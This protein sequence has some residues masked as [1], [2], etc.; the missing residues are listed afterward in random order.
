MT[1]D[2]NKVEPFGLGQYARRASLESS[3]WLLGGLWGFLADSED[4]NGQFSVIE[5]MAPKGLEPARHVH[6][7]EDESF[8]VLEGK[9]T[10]YVGEETYESGPGTFVFLPRGVPHSF[11]FET[12]VVRMLTISAPAG[13]EELF[14][15]PSFSEPA[16]ALTLPPPPT[17]PP[18]MVALVEEA[19]S[20]GVEI[21]G[22][23]G[24]PEQR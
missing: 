21:V 6:H 17:G 10:Y 9:I 15:D 23:P 12:D 1:I 14:R 11:T 3:V 5:I 24:P 22:P 4:T 18:D 7:R 13:I 8:Y 20:Y 2:Y 16:Q 19:A